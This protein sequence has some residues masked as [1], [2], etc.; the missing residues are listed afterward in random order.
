MRNNKPLLKFIKQGSTIKSIGAV[1]EVPSRT[2]RWI[3]IQH[4]RIPA[5][6]ITKPSLLFNT[7]RVGVFLALKLAEKVNRSTHYGAVTK[8]LSK[9]CDQDWLFE[10]T[11]H[12]PRHS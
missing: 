7:R 3:T 11:R 9:P 10:K 8:G 5:K 12:L 2:V 4:C 6:Y 1:L